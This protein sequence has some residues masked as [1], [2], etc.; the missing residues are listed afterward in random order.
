MNLNLSKELEFLNNKTR[1]KALFLLLFRADNFLT[2]KELGQ[3]LNVTSRT[4]K[5]DI[6]ELKGYLSNVCKIISKRSSG[7]KL[8]I[9]EKEFREK[10]KALFQ[11]YPSFKVDSELDYHVLYILRKLV[12]TDRPIKVEDIQKELLFGGSLNKELQQVKEMLS[13][14]GLNLVTRPHY[15][16][17]VKGQKFK[18][19][20]LTVRIYRYFDK[21]TNNDFG[22]PEYNSFFD[23]S[24]QEKEQIRQTFLKTITQSRIVFSDINSERFIIY[25]LYFRNQ[26]LKNKCSDLDLQEIKFDFENTD[27]YELVIEI[28]QKLRNKFEGFDFSKEII[29]FL[30]YIAIFSTDLY[31]FSD[32]CKEKYNY[33]IPV[34]EETRNF[35]LKEMSEY[36]QIDAFDDYTCFK[37]L[38]KIMIPI[39]LKIMLNVS[40]SIDLRYKDFSDN[41]EQLVLKFYIKKLADKFYD[42]YNYE[43]SKRERH[44]IFLTFYGM[45]NRIMLEHRKLR[46]ALIAIDGRLSTQQM[47]FNLLHY[48]SEFIERIETKVLYELNS[49]KELNYDYYL[50]SSYGKHLNI[51]Q[52]PIY[53]V[54]DELSEADYVDSLRAI[55][56]GAFMYERKLPP[57]SFKRRK[58]N[59]KENGFEV[60]D[61]IKVEGKI[62]LKIYLNLSSDEEKFDIFEDSP[63]EYTF[64]IEL[65][66][67]EDRQKLKMLLNILNK[68]IVNPQLLVHLIENNTLS[69]G[70]F[71]I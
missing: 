14:Y 70:Y 22:I 41:G 64:Q 23:C 3:R 19:I 34:A 5:S 36:L 42:T 32:C 27:E 17:T 63:Y 50:C 21:N 47:K 12:S 53:Y 61:C 30:T 28:L 66:I 57:I 15:G 8:E 24:L 20:M 67:G 39:S 16:M 35:L 25:L 46:I 52:K 54:K 7:Y 9:P 49:E 40:D 1:L 26:I 59:T 68:L 65:K 48:F 2:S 37:D 55:F 51:S 62:K 43:F 56:F 69:Y 71:L 31:R 29:Q 38:L 33:L 11:I 44:L 60:E 10:I 13:K 4:V 58:S 6:N 18:E 45:L